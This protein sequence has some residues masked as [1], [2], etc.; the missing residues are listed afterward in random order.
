[1]AVL[2]GPPPV[3]IPFASLSADA[4]LGVLN[5]FIEREGTD[6]GAFEASLEKKHSDLVRQLEKGDVKLVF[7]PAT[8][9]VT[10]MTARE[11]RTRLKSP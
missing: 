2:D 1:M 5:D 11:W 6:Y 4:Q 7:D 8:E 9:S 3:E 10:L